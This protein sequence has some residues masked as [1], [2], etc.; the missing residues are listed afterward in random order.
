[1]PLFS[2]QLKH[3]FFFYWKSWYNMLGY[4]ENRQEKYLWIVCPCYSISSSPSLAVFFSELFIV[5]E[6]FY[7]K[8]W[9]RYTK[10][11]WRVQ[12]TWEFFSSW[13]NKKARLFIFREALNKIYRRIKS[14][15]VQIFL[16][17]QQKRKQ[18][19]KECTSHNDHVKYISTVCHWGLGPVELEKR[20]CHILEQTICRAIF[21]S[22][23]FGL[24]QL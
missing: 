6:N 19:Q 21:S 7:E 13:G 23:L 4:L 14:W 8:L 15:I 18:N 16:S 20:I 11:G 9:K 10:E 22:M 3:S 24:S 1:M 5:S 2:V 12:I 17:Y